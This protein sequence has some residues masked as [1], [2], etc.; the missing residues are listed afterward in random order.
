MGQ[1]R[2]FAI[3]S[4]QERAGLEPPR[5]Q[6]REL[7][8]RMQRVAFDLIRALE[9]EIS[10]IRDGDGSWTGCDPV[11]EMVIELGALKHKLYEPANEPVQP[12]DHLPF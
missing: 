10:G 11:S 7:L 5:G 6:Q 4:F 1:L 8:E 9:L 2:D 3:T 12:A